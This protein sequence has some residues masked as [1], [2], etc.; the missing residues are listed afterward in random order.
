MKNKKKIV[1]IIDT[2]PG[3]D[4]CAA[5]ALSLYDEKMDIRLITT[6]AGNLG[7]NKTTR[8]TLHL[9]EKFKRDDIPVVKGASKAMERISP[10]ATFIHQKEGMG[11]YVPPKTTNKQPDG[12]DATEAMYQ[13]IVENKNNID[14][15][16]LG[17]HTNLGHLIKKHPDVVGM[18]N[19][20]YC[21]GCAPYGVNGETHISFNVSTDPEA[22]KIVIES[23][24]PITIIPSRMGREITNFSEAE[25]MS[26]RD[27]NDAGR[28]IFEMYNGYWEPNYP[29]RRIATNDTCACMIMRFPKLFKTRRVNFEVDTDEK[30]GKTI[31]TPNRK[32][33]IEYAYKANKK[34]MHKL[35][36]NAIKKLDF[37]KFYED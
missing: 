26:L 13:C 24:I 29:D 1:C 34:K 3:V 11:G 35:F 2:D 5:L 7:L 20:I 37:L 33:H 31:I 8:N 4:D 21:E 10:D 30:P 23:G 16:A 18:V 17:P 27:I 14:I 6:L 19:H 32:S 36:F 9:L 25:V 15:I 28:F 12:R 22:F